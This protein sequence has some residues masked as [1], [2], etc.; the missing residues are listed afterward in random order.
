MGISVVDENVW[1]MMEVDEET[2]HGLKDCITA[3][4]DWGNRLRLSTDQIVVDETGQMIAMYFS[5]TAKDG[6][7]YQVLI[8]LLGE[9][10]RIQ[11]VN[12][13]FDE[14]GYA[15]LPPGM[16]VPDEDD[17]IYTAAACAVDPPAPILNATDTDWSQ[18]REN[19]AQF[20]IEI[21]ELC[22]GYIADKTKT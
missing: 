3:C 5:K 21:H 2:D 17:R 1:I 6:F 7:A 20:G 10:D 14:Y 22:P 18:C 9:S 19:L 8:N 15:V 11:F 13:A 4:K 16:I 12:I